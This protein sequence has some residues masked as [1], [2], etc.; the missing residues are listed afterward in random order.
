[1]FVFFLM[2][3]SNKIIKCSSMEPYKVQARDCIKKSLTVIR[4]AT[5]RDTNWGAVC[6]SDFG[7]KEKKGGKYDQFDF[8]KETA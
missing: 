2:L 7:E 3:H 5:G 1:M 6:Y 4:E 8:T